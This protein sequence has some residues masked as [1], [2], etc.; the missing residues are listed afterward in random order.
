MELSTDTRV[1][2]PSWINHAFIESALK[3]AERKKITVDSL[4]VHYAN[5]EG[6][7]YLSLIFRV[8]ACLRYEGNEETHKKTLIVKTTL[9]SG[10]LNA[11]AEKSDV[12]KTEAEMLYDVMP[13]L[14][15]QLA[16]LEG[17]EFRPLAAKCYQWGRQPATFLVMEDLS[18]AGFR[19]AQAGQPLDLKHCAVALRAYARLHAASVYLLSKQPH[20]KDNFCMHIFTEKNFRQLMASTCTQFFKA[21]ANELHKCPGYEEYSERYRTL[22]ECF[23]DVS[24]ERMEQIKTRTKLPVL[25]HGDCWKNNMMFKYMNGEVSEVRLVDFQCSSVTSPA[26]DLLYFLYSSA[27]EDVHRHH[28]ED[29]LR[30]YHSTLVGLLRRL[31]LEQQAEAYTFEELKEDMDYCLVIGVY[32]SIT[33]GFGLTSEE[34][35][36]EYTK[37][38][39]DP[40]KFGKVVVKSFRN[41]YSL[42]Y[43]KYLSPIFVSKGIL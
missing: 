29:L 42:S 27:S 39:N 23:L 33:S 13:Q 36:A 8:T 4:S 38:V 32:F 22:A 6:L 15:E 41:P 24:Y 34:H 43:I 19:L 25:T 30:E 26:S 3:T 37:A 11:M 21:L 9:G 18:M 2:P 31:G 16:A 14:Y 10:E 7:G 40:E 28:V 17:D 12:F 20:Y 5:A 1:P 35:G